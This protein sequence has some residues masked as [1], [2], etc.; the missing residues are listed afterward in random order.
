MHMLEAAVLH[1]G[2]SQEWLTSTTRLIMRKR[3][4]T[5]SARALATIIMV[6]MHGLCEAGEFP[7]LE[8]KESSP[9]LLLL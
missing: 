5:N 6:T 3:Q 8:Q 7:H 4:S 1:F 2:S 9:H